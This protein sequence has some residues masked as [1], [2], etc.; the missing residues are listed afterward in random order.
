MKRR[1][2]K[3]DDYSDALLKEKLL[4]YSKNHKGPIT[5]LA[6]E[7]FSGISRKTWRRR[8]EE[9]ITNLNNFASYSNTNL[10]TAHELPLP[11]I[12]IIIDKY[13]FIPDGLKE[14]L[15][16]LNEVI[17][18]TH[19]ENI[20]LKEDLQKKNK[21]EDIYCEKI[22]KLESENKKLSNEVSY[23]ER[24]CIDSTNS[25]MRKQLGLKNNLIEINQ[26]NKKS[27]LSLEIE[28][29]FPELFGSLDED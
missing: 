6:L 16:H 2:G 7:K 11:S 25:S 24:L 3:P 13:Q 29:E 21:L 27:A 10:N 5:Y 17:L 26:K 8:M 22:R 9:I 15:Y 4:E 19:E 23:Y 20:K 28:G 14:S 1:P 18:K 12:D